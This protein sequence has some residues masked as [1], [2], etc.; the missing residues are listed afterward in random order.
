M[1]MHDI[2]I[3]SWGY[4]AVLVCKTCTDPQHENGTVLIEGTGHEGLPWAEA[5]GAFEKHMNID[6]ARPYLATSERLDSID[7][8]GY[9]DRKAGTETPAVSEPVERVAFGDAESY[10][11][12]YHPRTGQRLE[13]VEELVVEG[14]NDTDE[15]T[16]YSHAGH[17]HP[18]TKAA[19]AQCRKERGR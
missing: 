12:G 3:Q 11:A 13:E 5:V 17:D 18:Q 14:Y 16:G 9:E 19:R 6:P 7:W 10:P 2:R 1:T 4:R 8:G 15:P